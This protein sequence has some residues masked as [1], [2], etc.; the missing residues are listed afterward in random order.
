M[1]CRELNNS[2]IIE[3]IFVAKVLGRAR[4]QSVQV[5]RNVG[6]CGLEAVAWWR[7][8]RLY[9]TDE[10]K[11]QWRRFHMR[12]QN[13]K[14][15]QCDGQ[16]FAAIR[17]RTRRVTRRGDCTST[18]C[19]GTVVGGATGRIPLTAPCPVEAWPGMLRWTIADELGGRTRRPTRDR[20]RRKTT[21]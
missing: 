6:L 14:T 7:T 1:T 13:D 12:R 20:L 8:R 11:F 21:T 19:S 3:T 17:V 2:L 9:K 5:V 18:V 10:F 15:A 4:M 16:K